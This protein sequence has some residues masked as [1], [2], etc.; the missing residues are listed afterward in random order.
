MN[1][2]NMAAREHGG[3]IWIV[4]SAEFERVVRVSRAP[5]N[6]AQ[7]LPVPFCFYLRLVNF[8]SVQSLHMISFIGLCERRQDA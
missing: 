7:S 1:D 6:D 5:E 8:Q 3:V 2:L 4:F